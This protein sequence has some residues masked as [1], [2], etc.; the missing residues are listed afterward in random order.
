MDESLSMGPSDMSDGLNTFRRRKIERILPPSE[1][2]T[3]EDLNFYLKLLSNPF[4]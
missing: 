3:L 2:I 4:T 1:F